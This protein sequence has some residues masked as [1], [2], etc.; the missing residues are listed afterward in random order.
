MITNIITSL[1][2]APFIMNSGCTD[3]SKIEV[4]ALTT[5]EQHKRILDVKTR[6][7]KRVKLEIPV[8]K[9]VI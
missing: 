9:V 6:G 8:E 7:T 4:T 3:G 5:P 2:L 1:N